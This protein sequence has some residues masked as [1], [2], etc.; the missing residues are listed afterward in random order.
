M[1]YLK[2]PLLSAGVPKPTYCLIVHTRARYISGWIPRV[3]GYSPG[4]PRSRAGSK[5]ARSPGPYT[6][7]TGIPECSTTSLA[8]FSL[9]I[10]PPSSASAR[11][12]RA[13]AEPPEG[14]DDRR[15]RR[16]HG[17]YRPGPRLEQR[18]DVGLRDRAPHRSEEH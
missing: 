5:S 1:R 17:E 15:Q 13:A 4:T 8:F 12:L 18:R 3:K 9:V 10:A 7:F 14:L 16:A 6:G 2:R 11:A